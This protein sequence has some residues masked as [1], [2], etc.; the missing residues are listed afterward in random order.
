MTFTARYHGTCTSCEGHISPG[1][2]VAWV[3]DDIVHADCESPREPPAP[4]EV[5]TECWVTKPCFCET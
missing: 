3:D 2:Q 4:A 5:C 1:D